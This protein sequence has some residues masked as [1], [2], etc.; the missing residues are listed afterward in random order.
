[1][2]VKD[3]ELI[4]LKEIA[5]NHLPDQ[6]KIARNSS[7]SLGLVNLIIKRLVAKGLI[8][9]KRLDKKRI[10]YIM[11]AKGFA[12]QTK[13]S[14]QYTLQTIEQLKLVN[15]KI[16]ALVNDCYKKGIREILILADKDVA[17]MIEIGIKSCSLDGLQYRSIATLA[18][19]HIGRGSIIF[20][21]SQKMEEASAHQEENA[22]DIIE[23]L[24]NYGVYPWSKTERNISNA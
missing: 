10:Q 7:F 24:A 17:M 5:N 3:K 9:T 6:R 22:V 4:I 18:D 20:T 14:Y 8:K 16:Q 1:M 11:T 2:E 19:G 23:Y 13:R 21:V 15:E 12:A